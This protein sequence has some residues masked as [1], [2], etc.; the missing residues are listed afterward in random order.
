MYEPA[1]GV[2][3]ARAVLHQAPLGLEFSRAFPSFFLMHRQLNI[4]LIPE[5]VIVYGS[6]E[7]FV[8]KQD[9]NKSST[10]Y[11]TFR[12]SQNAYAAWRE[13]M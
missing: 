3:P 11:F 2:K 1:P 10:A 9:T 6:R 13:S 8:P 7:H 12:V 5:C 4:L